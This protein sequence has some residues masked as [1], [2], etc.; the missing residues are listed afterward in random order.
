[1]L[2]I[3]VEIVAV[4]VSPF[5]VVAE[6]LVIGALAIP[7]VGL[8]L[9]I[10]RLFSL[11]F[12]R[13]KSIV[14][15]AEVEAQL[16]HSARFHLDIIRKHN[17][18]RL[19]LRRI[20]VVDL[21]ADFLLQTTCLAHAISFIQL[22]VL[23]EGKDVVVEDADDA[24]RHRVQANGV[25][26]DRGLVH[27]GDDDAVVSPT[28]FRLIIRQVKIKLGFLLQHL[29][30]SAADARSDRHLHLIKII[31]VNA[32]LVEIES[33]LII[34]NIGAIANLAIEVHK[35]VEVLALF[36][37][38]RKIQRP[39][40]QVVVHIELHRLEVVLGINRQFVGR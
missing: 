34:L 7:I 38:L 5:A 12:L 3:V 10:V 28:H 15:R 16:V 27:V 21:E 22:I 8:N 32:R 35:T 26:I 24:Q 17:G 6:F 29:V 11:H 19:P 2:H 23:Q 33:Y 18:E 14:G 20:R 4:G 40:T 39:L 36:Q 13:G 30:I 31:A 1:M 37:R 25:E 9:S